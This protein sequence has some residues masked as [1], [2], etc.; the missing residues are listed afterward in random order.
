MMLDYYNHTKNDK[1]A[2]ETLLPFAQEIIT[3][4]DQHWGRDT[5][6]KIHFEPAM[7]LET[8]RKAVNPLVEIVGIAKVCN[9][10]LTLP[11]SMMSA[12][13][14]GQ[15]KR[16]ISELPAVPMREIDGKKILAPAHQYS[17]K[18]NVEN[19]EMYAVFPYR[20]YGVGKADIQIARNTF[21][22]RTHKNSGGWQQN[23]IQAA[24]LGLADEAAGLMAY[25]FTHKDSRHRFD[26]MW[27]PNYDWTPD[28]DH[29]S[30]AMMALQR[31]L[32][33][34]DGEEIHLLPAWP[35]KWDVEFKLHAPFKTLVEGT[36][37]DGR[38][39]V[40]NVEP[41]VRIKNIKIYK[42]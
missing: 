4:Y 21:A 25:N 18:Q 24:Y 13:Q 37:K 20:A 27:G 35:K 38:L 26:A 3:F 40:F 8:Y 15:W 39:E 6:G 1:F 7:A 34:Y 42:D 29:G 23:A 12:K 41:S 9:G 2:K 10:L 30:V 28:Q 36:Y 22:R 19:P 33:Q 5:S 32:I 14:L 16:L 11:D 31:M 17:E